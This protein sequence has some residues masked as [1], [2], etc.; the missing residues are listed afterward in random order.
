MDAARSVVVESVQ[1]TTV[2]GDLASLEG[3][4]C[5]EDIPGT[6]LNGRKPEELKVSVLKYWP[7]CRGA[8]TTGRKADL[9]AQ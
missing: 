4:I 7:A 9:V 6:S 1:N 5:E 2:V 3:S 8:P